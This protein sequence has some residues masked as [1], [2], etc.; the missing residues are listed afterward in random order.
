MYE[1]HSKP[2][3]AIVFDNK[4]DGFFSTSYDGTLRHC[5]LEKGVFELVMRVQDECL[6]ACD[7][8]D[9]TLLV[10]LGNG[11]VIPVDY[12]QSKYVDCA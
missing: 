10:G 4:K 2:V 11:C 8:R 9:E 5:N 6:T 3:S 1:P 7:I 12:R